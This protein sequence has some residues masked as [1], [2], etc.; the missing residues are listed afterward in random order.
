MLFTSIAINGPLGAGGKG[1]GGVRELLGAILCKV[2]LPKAIMFKHNSSWLSVLNTEGRRK[3]SRLH[4]NG[5]SGVGP[6]VSHTY[7]GRQLENNGLRQQQMT[8]MQEL[9]GK[10]RSTQT[11]F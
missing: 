4:N 9:Q 3:L 1:G 10:K 5:I 6:V 2:D 7:A 11:T 8:D